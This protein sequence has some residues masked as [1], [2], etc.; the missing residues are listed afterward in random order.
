MGRTGESRDYAKHPTAVLPE[1]SSSPRYPIEETR[2]SSVRV[3]NAVL[4][5]CSACPLHRGARQAVVGEGPERAELMF[6]GEQPRTEEDRTGRPFIGAAGKIFNDALRRA[7]VKRADAYVTNAV[8]HSTF[9]QGA[10]GGSRVPMRAS[11]REVSVCSFWLKHELALVQPKV[12][13]C[14]GATAARAILGRDVRITKERGVVIDDGERKIV[15]TYH[16]SYVLRQ[17]EPSARSTIF[18]SIVDDIR[19]ASDLTRATSTARAA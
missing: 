12:V 2:L 9:E 17:R 3:L 7:G 6:V 15:I 16:P 14:L 18:R 13:V 8:K 1:T 10:R 19:R 11:A 4:D 5:A